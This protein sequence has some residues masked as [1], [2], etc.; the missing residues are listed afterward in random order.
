MYLEHR[1]CRA[2]G[3][4]QPIT[5]GGI[6][7]APSTEKLLPV[8]D[9][10]VQPLA[11]DFTRPED[12]K[13][14]F[15]PLK[16]LFCPR[17]SL[18]QLSVVVKPEILYRNYLYVT[19]PSA[20]MREHLENIAQGMALE[21]GSKR[22]LE[23][24]SNDGA[25]LDYLQTRGWQVM[26]VDPANNLCAKA[27]EKG[28]DMVCDFFG[29][30]SGARLSG[31]KPGIVLARHVFCHIDDWRDFI[32]GLELV[33]TD[34]TLVCIEVPYVADLLS[35]GEFDTIYHEHTSYLTIKALSALLAESRFRLQHIMH[36]TIHGGALFIML[37]V[38]GHE[39]PPDK[40]VSQFLNSEECGEDAWEKFQ[41]AAWAKIRELRNFVRTFRDSGKRVVGYGAS[42]KSTVW[43]N[44][45]GFTRKDIEAV[46]D[47]TA[48]KQ[49]RFI[50][51]T[52]IPIVHEGA[53]YA[54]GA[55][56]AVMF[57]WNFCDEVI[58][59]QRKWLQG[60]GQFIVPHP[61]IRLVSAKSDLIT[62]AQRV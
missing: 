19:S 12:E 13:S 15:A 37:R 11:N 61:E 24:G 62:K 26:G 49:F 47:G 57:C 28:I 55:D 34:E 4:G 35:K 43:I 59:K 42:A 25:F 46:Y 32:R 20:T 44:A 58:Q 6:K 1:T 14:G 53:F 60:G 54:D 18:A 48:E 29:A 30:D 40:S 3:Y 56:Y 16:V 39:A 2:C 17:C 22:L 10:G 52:D 23:I 45:C 27:K 41:K 8:F 7:S 31:F 33:S 38:K 9:L 21:A 50:P 5:P 36:V 51:G